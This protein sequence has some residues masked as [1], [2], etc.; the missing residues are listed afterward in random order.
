MSGTQHR[1]KAG[2]ASRWLALGLVATGM[3][4]ISACAGGAGATAS[5]PQKS[6]TSAPS[7]PALPHGVPNPDFWWAL[8]TLMRTGLP[9]VLPGWLPTT[10]IWGQTF[11][12]TDVGGIP[13]ITFRRWSGQESIDGTKLGPGYSI[14]VGSVAP[15]GATPVT[16]GLAPP[17]KPAAVPATL[18]SQQTESTDGRN[19]PPIGVTVA[20]VSHPVR[21]VG[22]PV[23]LGP[24]LVYLTAYVSEGTMGSWLRLTF[25]YG[26]YLVMVHD[27]DLNPRVA[28]QIA[29]SFVRVQ[30]PKRL[31]L[32]YGHTA[33]QLTAVAGAGSVAGPTQHPGTAW[34]Y[35]YRTTTVPTGS[36]VKTS[37]LPPPVPTR[38]PTAPPSLPPML[39]NLLAEP[40]LLPLGTGQPAS[41]RF[42]LFAAATPVLVPTTLPAGLDSL[43]NAT[44]LEWKTPRGYYLG[45]LPPGTRAGGIFWGWNPAGPHLTHPT[46]QTLDGH[47]VLLG[48]NRTAFATTVGPGA[49]A[50]GWFAAPISRAALLREA[51]IVF[52]PPVV[53]ESGPLAAAVTGQRVALGRWGWGRLAV[54]GH[55]AR[56]TFPYAR[57][58]YTVTV[59]GF[60]HAGPEA[61]VIAESLIT[62][63]P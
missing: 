28:L 32:A 12:P 19:T 61:L 34:G 6:L 40:P 52:H 59:R 55:T 17:W 27:P 36:T 22:R 46:R 47:D 56:L 48:R 44:P 10:G 9:V 49:T 50:Y 57:H 41:A 14:G 38:L 5:A 23:Q 25:R 24:L 43:P 35:N 11:S 7:L 60:S 18:Q 1:R 62:L 3:A 51:Q 26:R 37:P 30:M 63:Q 16:A 42:N 29:A 53:V 58:T 8:P 2:G 54:Q 33:E 21:L 4:G 39:A 20:Y 31:T 45:F 13:P 15:T